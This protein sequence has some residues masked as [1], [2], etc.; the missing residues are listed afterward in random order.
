MQVKHR[1]V[2][3]FLVG[4]FGMISVATVGVLSLN[5]DETE[6]RH[7]GGDLMPKIEYI[8]RLSGSTHYLVRS[9]YEILATEKLPS[10]ESKTEIKRFQGRLQE[11]FDTAQ[12]MVRQYEALPLTEQDQ[13]E[14]QKFRSE[15]DSW[16]QHDRSALIA[17]EAA[18]A[19]PSESAF[20]EVYRLIEKGNVARVA[21]GRQMRASLDEMVTR[22]TAAGHQAIQAALE[23][24]ARDEI[25]M[26]FIIAAAL[27]VLGVFTFSVLRMAIKPLEQARNVVSN[28]AE[29]LDLTLRLG[30]ESRDEIG[31]LSHAFDGMLDR[32]QTVFRTIQS[33]VDEVGKTVESVNTSAG[34][35]AQSSSSQSSSASAMAA[36]IQEMSVSINTVSSSAVEA[37]S[38]A[39]EAG[40]LSAQGS[41][42]I[43]RTRDE[44]VTIAQIVSG[45]SKVIEMLGE[46][47]HQITS[48]VNVIKEVADQTNLL[49]LNAAIEA[50]RAG[51][52]GRGFAVVADEVRKLAE[53]TAQ[54]TV[55]ISEMV[56][57]I[58]TSASEAVK[59]M[60]KVV[61]QVEA[62]QVMA[63]EAGD[64]MQSIR[65][66][67][68]RVSG[69][70]TEISDALKEQNSASHDVARH[71][72]SIAQMTDENSAAAGE[73]AE[74]AK[75]LDGLANEVRVALKSFRT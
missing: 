54:S 3:L 34:Q 62:G 30:I 31:Q 13:V 4:L 70:V 57:K 43:E 2:G 59:E 35:V 63:Q 55:D 27:G 28:V 64:R 49:A 53:R 42:I 15:W 69:A 58:Q 29:D 48:V 16:S 50:A 38:M 45:A 36:A 22:Q 56:G 44:M 14:W 61:T 51:E 65:E 24:T 39:K 72:E 37:Q 8:L 74:N 75:R 33:Q 17:L 41:Q 19:S 21:Q 6:F 7:L 10:A 12:D 23:G 9:G 52:Q 46:E 47:S 1:V 26:F 73:A 67:A 32:L 11:A 71:V 60:G 25:I 66:G 68:S 40:E 5:D 18:F 20:H